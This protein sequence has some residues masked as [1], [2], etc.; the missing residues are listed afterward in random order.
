[1]VRNIVILPILFFFSIQVQGQ[2][3]VK[4]DKLNFENIKFKS[5]TKNL[6]YRNLSEN[7]DTMFM[8]KIINYWFDNK[9]KTDGFDGSLEIII[10]NIETKKI[11]KEDYFKFSINLTIEFHLKNLTLGQTQTHKV[12]SSEYGEINGSFTIHEQENLAIDTMYRSVSSI[13]KK[14]LQIV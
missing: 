4:P 12:S 7:S 11:K 9:V 1:M 10:K 3:I 6:I 5:V 2:Q 8:K 14:I 13:S